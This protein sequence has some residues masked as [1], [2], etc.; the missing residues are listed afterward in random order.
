VFL[1]AR[2]ENAC[3]LSKDEVQTGVSLRV[4]VGKRVTSEKAHRGAVV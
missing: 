3:L 4:Q 1:A 2:V